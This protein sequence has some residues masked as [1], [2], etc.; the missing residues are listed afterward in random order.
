MYGACTYTYYVIYV[1]S[2]IYI[3]IYIDTYIGGASRQ[4]TSL[5]SSTHIFATDASTE[6]RGVC[7]IYTCMYMCVY[8]FI[9]AYFLSL[10]RARSLFLSA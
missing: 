6:V 4:G 7:F 2:Y 8:I 1:C 5:S 10:S 9:H 3:Y